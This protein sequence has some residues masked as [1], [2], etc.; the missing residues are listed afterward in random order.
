M[1]YAIEA[2]GLVK[3]LGSTLALAGVDFAVRRGSVLG[4]LGPN[5]AGKTTA[6]RSWPRCWRRTPG[7]HGW[8]ATT[9]PPSRPRYAAWSA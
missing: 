6:V 1:E 5:G 2:E 9:W 8:P 7:R 3:R 4:M